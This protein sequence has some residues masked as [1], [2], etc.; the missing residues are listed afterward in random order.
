VFTIRSFLEFVIAMQKELS[1]GAKG[2]ENTDLM[3]QGVV[4]TNAGT[5]TPRQLLAD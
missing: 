5:Y 2:W 4:P 3:R 1:D